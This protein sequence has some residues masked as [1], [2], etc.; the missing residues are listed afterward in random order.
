M[1]AQ[2]VIDPALTGYLAAVA[3]W[4]LLVVGARG[5]TAGSTVPLGRVTESLLH[6]APCPT[7]VY[8]A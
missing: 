5:R 3:G 2:G 4:D 8:R 6:Q 7:L 1:S